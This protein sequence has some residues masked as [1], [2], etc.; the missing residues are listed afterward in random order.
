MSAHET[1]EDLIARAVARRDFSKFMTL[2]WGF[3]ALVWV[4]VVTMSGWGFAPW[5]IP[6]SAVGLAV[7]ILVS[8]ASWWLRA[9]TVEQLISLSK[10]T[11]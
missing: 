2:T 11:S 5:V 6:V 9:R 4:F 7:L 3:V 8:A 1:R 10:E